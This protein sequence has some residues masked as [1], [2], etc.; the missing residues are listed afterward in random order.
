M[1]ITFL[2]S[3]KYKEKMTILNLIFNLRP[4][5]KV[6]S[7]FREHEKKLIVQYF[8][9]LISIGYVSIGYV[10]NPWSF[11]RDKTQSNY[12]GFE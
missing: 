10:Y 11:I 9:I 12:E 3:T 2:N 5:R 4:T 7:L 6:S 1:K 8:L